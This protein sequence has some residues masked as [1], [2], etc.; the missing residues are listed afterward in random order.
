MDCRDINDVEILTR[1]ELAVRVNGIK[2]GELLVIDWRGADEVKWSEN[3]KYPAG[4]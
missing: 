4:R 2:D 1:N 3:G